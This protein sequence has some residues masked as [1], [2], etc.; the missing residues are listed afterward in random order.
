MSD[1][2]HKAIF[3]KW[4]E[5]HSSSVI[6]VARAYTLTMD[7]R[8]DLAQEILFQAWKSMPKFNGKASPAT[9]FYRV[10]LHTAIPE[11]V[12]VAGR[13]GGGERGVVHD[14]ALERAHGC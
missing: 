2:D 7:E 4:L 13:N 1:E 5:E 12:P 6:K 8:Q 3:T 11:R 10:A 9:W 14:A